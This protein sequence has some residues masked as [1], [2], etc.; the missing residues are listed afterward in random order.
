MDHSG[1]EETTHNEVSADAVDTTVQ[2]G[3]VNGGV[4]LYRT[5]PQNLIQ[6]NINNGSGLF[7]GIQGGDFLM[8]RTSIVE[9]PDAEVTE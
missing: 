4:R 8:H 5:E 1:A 2:A 6:N 9:D 7:V 3:I